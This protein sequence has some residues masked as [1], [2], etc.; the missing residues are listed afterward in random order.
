MQ[1]GIRPQPWRGT[2]G[3][4]IH[5]LHEQPRSTVSWENHG[6][7]H[8]SQFLIAP[9]MRPGGDTT[10][11][12]SDPTD[13]EHQVVVDWPFNKSKPRGY[14]VTNLSEESL[15]QVVKLTQLPTKVHGRLEDLAE[16]FGLRDYEGRTFAGWHHHVTLVSAAY[17][18]SLLDSLK[19]TGLA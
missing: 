14:W 16:R 12:R 5:R 18:F 17:I 6:R 2:A 13:N 10:A 3:D 7:T 15:S 11:D 19:A 8:R 1:P 4:L 9:I